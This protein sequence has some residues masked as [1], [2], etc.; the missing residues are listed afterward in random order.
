[1]DFCIRQRVHPESINAPCRNPLGLCRFLRVTWI[2]NGRM[3]SLTIRSFMSSSS[4][5]PTTTGRSPCLNV[6]PAS[7]KGVP[8]SEA[9]VCDGIL[10]CSGVVSRIFPLDS[11]VRATGGCDVGGDNPKLYVQLDYTGNTGMVVY[12]LPPKSQVLGPTSLFPD[13]TE[14]CL[15]LI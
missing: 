13:S 11:G 6:L 9:R 2:T 14:V 12:R 15:K 4:L 1:M 7:L 3:G 5:S 10:D 8:L